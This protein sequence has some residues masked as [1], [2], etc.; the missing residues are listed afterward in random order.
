MENLFEFNSILSFGSGS[1]HYSIYKRGKYGYIKTGTPQTPSKSLRFLITPKL[2][3]E[4]SS[5]ESCFENADYIEKVLL[6]CVEFI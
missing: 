4:I 5:L 2:E 1:K 3:T 6:R